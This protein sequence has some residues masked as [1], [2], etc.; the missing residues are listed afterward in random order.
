MEENNEEYNGGADRTHN[1]G[2]KW[3]DEEDERL[4]HGIKLYGDLD[5]RRISELVGT[6]AAGWY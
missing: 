5:W 6:R 1:W 4:I 3:S 2:V